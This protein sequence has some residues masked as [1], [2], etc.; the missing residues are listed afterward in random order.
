MGVR[1]AVLRARS[2]VVLQEGPWAGQSVDRVVLQDR[3]GLLARVEFLPRAGEEVPRV[4][5]L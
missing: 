4:Q 5:A 2:P 1:S 3:V